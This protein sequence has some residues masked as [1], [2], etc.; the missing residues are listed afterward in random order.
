[1]NRT[2]VFKMGNVKGYAYE[3][4]EDGIY[5][6]RLIYPILNPFV[7][8]AIQNSYAVPE[9]VCRNAKFMQKMVP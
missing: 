2:I 5:T 3:P 7:S 9:W 6:A 1:M 4:G 8:E